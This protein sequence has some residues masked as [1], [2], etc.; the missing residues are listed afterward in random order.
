MSKVVHF[1]LPMTPVVQR[2]VVFDRQCV[3]SELA[4]AN[5]RENNTEGMKKRVDDHIQ[6]SKGGSVARQ[7][8]VQERNHPVT[9]TSIT[10]SRLYEPKYTFRI[11]PF[12]SSKFVRAGLFATI[13]HLHMHGAV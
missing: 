11:F 4:A 9:E 7:Q 8:L 3:F 13:V 10:C 6:V 5:E 12:R 2:G 1:K